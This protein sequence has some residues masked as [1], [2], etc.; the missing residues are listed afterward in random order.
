M[1]GFDKSDHAI[2]RREARSLLNLAEEAFKHR[3]LRLA[4]E[5]I[6]SVY[7]YQDDC[8]AYASLR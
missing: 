8:L 4:E 2:T 7:R 3:N 6:E 5:L 1:S